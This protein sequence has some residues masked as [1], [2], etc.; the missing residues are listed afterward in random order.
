MGIIIGITIGVV[1]FAGAI[2]AIIVKNRSK[3]PTKDYLC[4]NTD[5]VICDCEY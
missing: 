3:E 1:A 2:M 5:C 4:G